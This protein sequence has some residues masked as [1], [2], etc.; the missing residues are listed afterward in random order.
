[1]SIIAEIYPINEERGHAIA[2][3]L[4]GLAFGTLVGPT[5]GGVLYELWGKKVPFLI[6]SSLALS[7][8]CEYI[9]FIFSA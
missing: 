9:F 5:Y 1:M 4:S 7:G 3:A 8:A 2:F 6:L